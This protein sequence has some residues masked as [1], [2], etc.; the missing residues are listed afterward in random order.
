MPSDRSVYNWAVLNDDFVQKYARARQSWAVAEFE[1]MMHIMDTPQV[2]ETIE[3]MPDG[4][5]KVKIGDMLEHR[6][7]QIDTR[8]WALARMF[9]KVY[10]EAMQLRH[11]DANG[12][13]LTFRVEDARQR[14]APAR[15]LELPPAEQGEE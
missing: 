2:G 14:I 6:R 11:A 1:R 3:V 15:V 4:R 13:Q 5:R 9:P 10:G 7:L 8:K 12:D